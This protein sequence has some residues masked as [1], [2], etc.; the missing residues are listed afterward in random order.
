[1]TQFALCP[2]NVMFC[3]RTV[4]YFRRNGW[5]VRSRRDLAGCDLVVFSACGLT[6]VNRDLHLNLIRGVKQE[7]ADGIGGRLVVTGCL[8]GQAPEHLAAIHD[9]LVIPFLSLSQFDDLIA[10]ETPLDAIPH[11]NHVT[12]KERS[13][14]VVAPNSDPGGLKHGLVQFAR[15]AWSS[16]THQENGQ[17]G[18]PF[19]YFLMGDKT[20]CIQTSTGCPKRCSFCI[21]HLAR[22]SLRSRPKD[23]ILREARQGLEHGYRYISLIADNNGVYGQDIGTS[24]GELLDGLATIRGEFVLVVEGLDAQDFIDVYDSFKALVRTGKGILPS[25]AMQHVNERILRSMRRSLDVN[26][27]KRCLEEMTAGSEDF[28]ADLHFIAGYP[29]ETEEEFEELVAFARW[30]LECNPRFTWKAFKFEPSPGSG[31]AELPNQLP[32]EVIRARAN[33]LRNLHPRRPTTLFA[34][35]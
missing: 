30:A 18:L 14:L 11:R 33:H 7:M 32:V 25:L 1:M 10:A 6:P 4:D 17:H 13:T 29:G 8:P 5:Q 2:R 28:A 19:D 20:W 12:T 24:F 22:G 3:Y 34:F 15:T 21:S 31:A 35:R 26:A 23:E 16:L 9:G 27:L